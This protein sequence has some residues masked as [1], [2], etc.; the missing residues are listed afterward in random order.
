MQLFGLDKSELG[1]GMTDVLD[2]I[3]CDVRLSSL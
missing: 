3:V 1:L 2:K